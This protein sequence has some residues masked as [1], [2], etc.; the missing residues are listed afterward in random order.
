MTQAPRSLCLLRTPSLP[1]VSLC[2]QALGSYS[3][4]CPCHS[5]GVAA[6]ARHVAKRVSHCL[7]VLMYPPVLLKLCNA[8]CQLCTAL[9]WYSVY[10]LLA[11]LSRAASAKDR[12]WPADDL[13][14]CQSPSAAIVLHIALTA[15]A[16]PTTKPR[17]G[18]TTLTW[19]GFWSG[20]RVSCSLRYL[21]IAPLGLTS[22]ALN[23]DD[24]EGE[25]AAIRHG[26]LIADESCLLNGPDD[27]DV[28]WPLVL[29]CVHLR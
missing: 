19:H 20:R 26:R 11:R 7:S 16:T 24:W 3:E 9:Q 13:P 29:F 8:P 1:S 28:G 6:A 22:A 4:D 25:E 2:R 27:A 21:R 23:A 18:P 14:R 10:S 12:C 15:I 17:V 5:S